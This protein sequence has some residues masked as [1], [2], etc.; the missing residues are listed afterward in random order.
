[1]R[2]AVRRLVGDRRYR[3]RAEEIAAWGAENDGATNAAELVEE[4]ARQGRRDRSTASTMPPTV[5]D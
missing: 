5:A 4:T 1:V 3:A 2:L